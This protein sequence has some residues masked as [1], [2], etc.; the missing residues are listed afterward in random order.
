[1]THE[2]SVVDLQFE[3]LIRQV[4]LARE[5]ARKNFVWHSDPR[6]WAFRALMCI[7]D[8]PDWVRIVLFLL[9]VTAVEWR[10]RGVRVTGRRNAIR[11]LSGWRQ[12]DLHTETT[13]DHPW[14]RTS[15]GSHSAD[16]PSLSELKFAL[17]IIRRKQKTVIELSIPSKNYLKVA[18]RKTQQVNSLNVYCVGIVITLVSSLLLL[19]PL[20]LTL[21]LLEFF[22]RPVVFDL[23]RLANFFSCFVLDSLSDLSGAQPQ[24]ARNVKEVSSGNLKWLT[25]QICEHKSKDINLPHCKDLRVPFS[26]IR[27]PKRP[28][29][30]LFFL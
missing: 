21:H 26:Y 3:L 4:L 24:Q 17:L 27:R 29:F 6:R 1:M 7:F 20:I 13:A 12:V 28:L 19:A 8:E 14:N 5:E 23:E 9:F 15:Q 30:Q 16:S 2:A 10:S 25:D 18:K 11:T 22:R